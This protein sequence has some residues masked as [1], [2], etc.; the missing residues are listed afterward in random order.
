M[1]LPASLC[2]DG[3]HRDPPADKT[4]GPQDHKIG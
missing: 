2:A 3:E 4:R 1:Q